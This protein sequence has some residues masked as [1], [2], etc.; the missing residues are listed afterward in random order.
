MEVWVLE[1]CFL[2]LMIGGMKLLIFEVHVLLYEGIDFLA[3][4][5]QN[6]HAMEEGTTLMLRR[7]G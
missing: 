6:H 2:L 3:D 1:V 7:R 5:H 4:H